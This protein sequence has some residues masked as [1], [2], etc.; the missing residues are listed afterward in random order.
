MKNQFEKDFECFELNEADLK[1]LPDDEVISGFGSDGPA[2][3]ATTTT[4]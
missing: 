4:N 1:L 2:D 3:I